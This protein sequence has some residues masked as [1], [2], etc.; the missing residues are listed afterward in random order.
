MNIITDIKFAIRLLV[1]NPSSSVMAIL[2]MA[3]GTGVAITMFSFVNGLL[4]SSLELN[5]EREIF[6]IEWTEKDRLKNST[7]LRALDYE[8]LKAESKGFEKMTSFRWD[9]QSLYNP[10]EEGFAKKYEMAFVESDF[11]EFVDSAPLLGRTFLPEDASSGK[12][13]KLVI[14]QSVWQEHFGGKAEA[15]GSIAMLGGQ[16]CTIVGVMPDGFYFPDEVHVWVATNWSRAREMGRMYGRRIFS[17]GILG[18]GVTESQARAELDTVAGRLAQEFPET[19]EELTSVKLESYVVWFTQGGLGSSF[20]VI[21]YAL[22]FCAFLVL[23][24][25]SANVFNLVMTRVATRTSEL[26]IRSAM[27]ARRAQIVIQ[28]MLDGLILTVLGATGG[29]LIAGW[30]LKLI[31]AKFSTQ[32]YIPYW[33]HMDMN[34]TVIGF[35]VAIVILSALASSLVPGL[36][37]ARSS[38]AENLKDD[39][40]TSSSLFLGAL[41]KAILGF[42]ITVTGVL[43][44]VSV[45]MV[46]VWI[47][48]KSRDYPFNPDSLLSAQLQI[49]ADRENPSERQRKMSLLK[50]RIMSN[51]GVEAVAFYEQEG[52]GAVPINGLGGG[53]FQI[54]IEGEV[55]ESEE[56]KPRTRRV[57][58][59]EGVESVF[60]I[61]PLI[62]RSMNSLDS[63]ESEPVCAVNKAFADMYWPNEDPIGKRIKTI[64]SDT[65][66][67]FRTVVGVVQNVLPNP[68]PGEDLVEKGYVKMYIPYSQVEWADIRYLVVKGLS[69]MHI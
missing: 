21:C 65:K 57:I 22:L 19:N 12:E 17:L 4:W 34:G 26:S 30:S 52:G 41:S 24:V 48:M 18:D 8:V 25:A 49:E 50:E 56:S 31:W 11:F 6:Q 37:A 69:L 54:E 36:R 5:E 63:F 59:S 53:S 16:P 60:G 32:R 64:G 55:Y 9:N 67:G 2:V 51:P 33:W 62:G 66:R 45:M 35:V 27:G 61:E 46:L 14:S 23:G 44:F 47:H 28:V 38:V 43:A 7:L 40:R 10:S 15:I 29:I 68:M 1:K 58:V 20:E 3:V 13:D 42:Q 39:S